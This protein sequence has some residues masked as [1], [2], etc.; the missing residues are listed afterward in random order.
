MAGRR[1]EKSVPGAW[2]WGAEVRVD[3]RLR[4]GGP[5]TPGGWEAE[6]VGSKEAGRPSVLGWSLQGRPGSHFVKRTADLF[7]KTGPTDTE[8]RAALLNL[9]LEFYPRRCYP[10]QKALRN[11]YVLVDCHYF[12]HQSHLEI[13]S[14]SKLRVPKDLPIQCTY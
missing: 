3:A 5:H 10:N 1:V 11:H 9:N 7:L 2:G 12:S 8:C 13:F 14:H 4:S 6:R